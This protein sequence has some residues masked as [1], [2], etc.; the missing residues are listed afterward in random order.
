M[1][2]HEPLMSPQSAPGLSQASPPW[3][4]AWRGQLIWDY[5]PPERPWW[6]NVDAPQSHFTYLRS[7]L[8]VDDLP[9]SLWTRLTCDSRYI[10]YINGREAGRGP[11][12]E[13]PPFIGYDVLDLA[14]LLQSGPNVVVALCRYYGHA[15]PWWLPAP[16]SGTLG[17]GSFCFETHPDAPVQ[18]VSG[19]HWHAVPA[20]WQ[21]PASTAIFHGVPTEVIDLR[22]AP[23]DLNTPCLVEGRWPRAVVV[24]A[25]FGVAPDRLPAAPFT[26]VLEREIPQLTRSCIS[27]TLIDVRQADV[28]SGLRDDPVE[29]WATLRHRADGDRRLFIWDAGRISRGHIRV[30]VSNA[31]SG[32]VIDVGVGEA[33]RPDGMPEIRPR[34]WVG[35]IITSVQQNEATFFDAVGFRY[36]ALHAPARVGVE[37]EIEEHL[38]PPSVTGRFSADA[39]SGGGRMWSAGV[40][41]VG[42]CSTDALVDCPGREQ[43]AWLGDS[44]VQILVSLVSSDDHRL[45]RRALALATRSQRPDG[46]LAMAAACDLAQSATTI[47]D[48]SLHWIRALAAYWLYS[49]AEDFVCSLRRY[50]EDVIERYEAYR[51]PSGLLEN[52]PGWVF[53][54]W[55]QTD[56]DAV[57]AAHD[58]LYAAALT[59]Y[60]ALP[61]ADNVDA[62]IART[63]EGFEALWDDDRG[64]YVDALGRSGRSARVSQQ[65]NAAA[66]LAGI[67]PEDRIDRVIAGVVHPGPG[68]RGG[69][70][71]TTATFADLPE[72]GARSQTA[73]PTSFAEDR[74]VVAC[75]PFFAHFLH[76]ALARAGR[77][78]LL[79]TSLSRWDAWADDTFHEIWND[80]TRIASHCHGWSATPT[81]DLTTHILGLRPLTPGFE[82][83]AFEPFLG[84]GKRFGGA[85]PTPH[86]LLEAQVDGCDALVTVPA[87]VV[88]TTPGGDVGWG[89]H[90]LQLECH[91]RE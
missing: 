79:L 41:T 18:L 90:E 60:A 37:L 52:V 3:P 86:G 16:V 14:P 55:A 10:L 46:L 38:Y 53:I 8:H 51:G 19:E 28:R 5:A 69:R 71:V 24:R 73:A 9:G 85:I 68:A 35:R 87:G 80:H 82:R 20:P 15:N 50:A 70:L 21:P 39:E 72:L 36:V 42:L 81:Y 89:S 47:P 34:N 67:V 23:A 88:L 27:P 63:T 49:G 40:R 74:D 6:A 62:L 65:T 7:E 13:P 43:R 48:Y 1:L 44:H 84:A 57:T 45:V 30:R 54:D 31:S 83:A 17:S 64:V 29:T 11:V 26:A 61:G 78:D 66:V 76:Q 56:R 58:A 32:D 77:R 91:Q 59:D 33:R 22:L 4:A 75:Q 2:E 12:R 25:G